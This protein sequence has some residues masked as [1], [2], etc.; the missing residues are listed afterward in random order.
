MMQE[1][2]AIREAIKK[3]GVRQWRVA[4]MYGICEGN[5]S[6][7]LRKKLDENT[8]KRIF[9]IIQELKNAELEEST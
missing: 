3:A 6:R 1:N 9:S 4:E 2:M 7:L 8:T 5:F